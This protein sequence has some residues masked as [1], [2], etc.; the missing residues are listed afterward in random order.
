MPCVCSDY[1]REAV[2]ARDGSI[3]RLTRQMPGLADA[4]LVSREAAK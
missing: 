4:C 2:I 1:G 3:Q